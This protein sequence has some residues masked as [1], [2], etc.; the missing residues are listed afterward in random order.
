MSWRSRIGRWWPHARAALVVA[1]LVAIAL[2]A[3][4]TP[5]GGMNRAAWS[6]PTVQAEFRTWSSLVGMEPKAFEERLWRAGTAWS[7]AHEA[8][9]S[10]LQ[11]YLR[12]T[13][14]LQPWRMFVGP[15]RYP[16]RFEVSIRAGDAWRTLY[17]AK[18]DEHRWREEFFEHERL[19]NGLGRFAW[20]H[21]RWALRRLCTWTAR[22]AFAEHA[23]ADVVRCRYR[24]SRS[25]GP[26]EVSSGVELEGRW[27]PVVEVPRREVLP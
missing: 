16:G 4:P 6:A 2:A 8:V 20:P 26:K 13:G 17:E 7:S 1:H 9:T 14:T 24:R 27:D 3:L 19:R 21:M 25:P 15:E 23:D 11:P 5:S 12:A 18:S 10:P 22:E